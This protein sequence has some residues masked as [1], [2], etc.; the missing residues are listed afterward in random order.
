M[1]F[2][3]ILILYTYKHMKKIISLLVLTLSLMVHVSAIA[4]NDGFFSSSYNFDNEDPDQLR[5]FR[6]PDGP[7]GGGASPS[8]LSDMFGNAGNSNFT[9]IEVEVPIGNGSLILLISCISFV[10][11]KKREEKV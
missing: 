9:T 4:Q 8:E 7:T 2:L 6:G 11:I 10:L 3:H 5:E 1:L